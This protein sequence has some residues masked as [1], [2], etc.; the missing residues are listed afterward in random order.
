MAICPAVTC[1][2]HVK[3]SCRRGMYEV[4]NSSCY[5]FSFGDLLMNG[6]RKLIYRISYFAGD[7]FSP[8]IFI[9]LEINIIRSDLF[10]VSQ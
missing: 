8:S 10:N 5:S 3:L 1:L 9:M 6:T 2:F 7:L 4:S